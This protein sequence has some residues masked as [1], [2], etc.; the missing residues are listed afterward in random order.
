MRFA[1]VIVFLLVSSVLSAQKIQT[2]VP[3]QPVVIG[4]AF[5]VQYII[6]DP[7]GFNDA[8]RPQF[9][10]FMVVSGPNHYQGKAII[11]G[12]MQIIENITYTLVPEKT[13]TL[14]IPGIHAS[15]RTRDM[16]QS[17]PTTISVVPKPKM[18]F[19]AKSSYTDVSLYAPPTQRE[20]DR[21]INENIFIRAEVSKN[22]CYVGEPITASFK[23]YSRLQ[24]SSEMVRVPSLYGFSVV[25]I[26][27]IKE[28]HQAVET[29]NGKIFNTSILRKIQLYPEQSGDLLIDE[30]VV[31]N[32]IEFDDSL[33]SDKKTVVEK[34]LRTSPVLIKVKPL[35]KSKPLS[36]T[37]AVGQFSL[38]VEMEDNEISANEQGMFRLTISG[39][40]NFI[41]LSEP[42]INWPAGLDIFEPVIED[43]LSTSSIPIEGKRT[44]IYGVSSDSAGRFIIPQISFSYFD[45]SKDSF[46]KLTTPAL[47]LNIKQGAIKSSLQN[48]EEESLSRNYLL[49]VVMAFTSLIVLLIFLKRKKN[50]KQPPPVI[51]EPF[52]AVSSR[53]EELNLDSVSDKKACVEITRLLSE[54]QMKNPGI[55]LEQ[56]RE[57]ENIKAD[58]QMMAYSEIEVPG[59]KESLKH[60]SAVLARQVENV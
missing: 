53:I 24:S 18:S 37:G 32:E 16:V 7:T 13:G 44:F 22:T 2:I 27:D 55:S 57:L 19:T 46:K 20:M 41:Q 4:T 30:M 59:V 60:R 10:N 45:V 15:F 48:K 39:K 12:R 11:D 33:D 54:L 14:T 35:P 40:G 34:E 26:L 28:S 50:I 5:Q 42:V 38:A 43:E 52:S 17:N 1:V 56:L 51:A 31:K 6:I 25:D 47:E 49:A 29:I 36:F 8:Q 58:C 9:E 23:L 21:M 3:S